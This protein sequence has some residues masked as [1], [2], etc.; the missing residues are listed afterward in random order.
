[1]KKK[2][3]LILKILL[4]ILLLV[5]FVGLLIMQ[6]IQRNKRLEVIGKD[7]SETESNV[8][9]FMEPESFVSDTENTLKVESET[10]KE[11][12]RI[13]I[14]NLAELAKQIMGKQSALLEETLYQFNQSQ[15]ITATEATILEVAIALDD[16]QCTEFYIENSD[17]T[18]VTIRWNP[19]YQTVDAFSC[20]YTK[21]EIEKSIWLWG[22]N[23]P[24]AH[25]ITPEEE[26]DFLKEKTEAQTEIL[27]DGPGEESDASESGK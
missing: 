14:S 26:Q 12:G 4:L 20:Q 6:W 27:T 11:T 1:M 16:A 18:L 23:E 2:K 8:F 21:T 13:V 15:G 22:E 10:I 3:A 24:E 25:G 7:M 17:G 9:D 19:Y 5:L